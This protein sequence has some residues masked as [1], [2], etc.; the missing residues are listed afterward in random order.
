MYVFIRLTYSCIDIY[1]YINKTCR[2][3]HVICFSVSKCSLFMFQ[4][5]IRTCPFYV[6]FPSCQKA[7]R[8]DF[9]RI[10]HVHNTKNPTHT[11]C[12]RSL[13]LSIYIY[14]YVNNC[15][16]MSIY[17]YICIEYMSVHTYI[18]I[19][20]CICVCIL[21]FFHTKMLLIAKTGWWYPYLSEKK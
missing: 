10:L 6:H 13:S 4:G 21:W 14:I 16:Y 11:T 8:I 20:T 5:W 3:L 9:Q 15:K 7:D 19:Y 2:C 17:I 12:S 18:Y 1:I